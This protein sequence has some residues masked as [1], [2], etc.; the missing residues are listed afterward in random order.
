MHDVLVLKPWG[1]HR[2][3]MHL[4]L[5]QACMMYLGGCWKSGTAV[6]CLML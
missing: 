6:H 4:L 5:C 3:H 1:G 2:L